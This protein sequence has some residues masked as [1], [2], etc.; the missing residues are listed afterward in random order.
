VV[1]VPRYWYAGIPRNVAVRQI[2]GESFG[3]IPEDGT[4]NTDTEHPELKQYL[5]EV[6]PDAA[7]RKA[8]PTKAV[9]PE[10]KKPKVEELLDDAPKRKQTTHKKNR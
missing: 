1:V 10:P 6:T 3:Y 8:I 2:A 4:Y 9:K 5:V 7:G